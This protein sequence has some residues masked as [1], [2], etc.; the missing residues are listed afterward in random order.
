MDKEETIKQ[1]QDENYQLKL[2]NRLLKDRIKEIELLK[3]YIKELEARLAQDE[4]AD[5]TESEIW[6]ESQKREE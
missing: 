5:F 1:L 3:E 4:N 2:D 6:P